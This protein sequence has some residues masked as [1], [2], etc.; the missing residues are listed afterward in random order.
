MQFQPQKH[1]IVSFKSGKCAETSLNVANWPSG[2]KELYC[3][4]KTAS[5]APCDSAITGLNVNPITLNEANKT[6]ST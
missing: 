2:L 4:F 5:N 6:E 1:C 3:S